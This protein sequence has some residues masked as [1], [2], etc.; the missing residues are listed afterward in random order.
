[1]NIAQ[2]TDNLEKLVESFNK[3]TFIFNLL[4]AYGTPKATISRLQK[5]D[6]NMFSK[7]IAIIKKKL[8]FN[9]VE[10][11]DLQTALNNLKHSEKVTKQSPRFIV[12]TDYETLLAYDTKTDESLDIPILEIAQ[13]TDFFLPWAGME[14]SKQQTENIADVRAAERMAKLY[15]EIRK[16]NPTTTHE[17]V[18]NLNVFLSRLLFCYFAEDTGIFDKDLFTKSI[19]YHTQKDGSDLSMYLD[20][21]F[22]VMNTSQSARKNDL[23]AYIKAF[24]YVNGGLFRDQH[25]APVFT[26]KSRQ[27]LIDCGLSLQWQ[28]INPDIFG[29]MIQAVITPE[30]RGGLGMHYTSVPNIMKVIEPLFLDELKEEFDAIV[31]TRRALSPYSDRAKLTFNALLK[32]IWNIKIFDP[33]CGSGNF[34]IIAYKE[35]RKLEMLIF[36]ELGTLAFSEINLGNFYGIELDDFAHEVATLS[37]WLAEHQMNQAFMREFGRCK[38]ALPLQETGNIVHGNACRIDWE[39]VCPKNKGD[40]IYILGNPPYLGGKGQSIEQKIDIE[41]IFKGE[42]NFKELDYIACWFLLAAKYIETK[43]KFAFVTTSSICEGAQ[44]EQIWPLITNMN[45]EIYFAY[46]PFNWTNN[47][48]NKAGVTCSI[49]GIRKLSTEKKYIFNRSIRKEVL[50][51]NGYLTSGDNIYITKNLESISRLPP[52]ITGNSPYENGNLMLTPDE[53]LDLLTNYPN[54]KQFIRKVTGANEYINGIERWCLWIEDEKL[55][56]ALDIPPVFKRIENIKLFRAAGG[57]VARG[58][59]NRPHKFRYTHTAKKSIIII[60]IVSSSRREYIPLGFLPAEYIILSSAAAIYD[61]EPYIF[62]ILTSKIH[63]NWVYLTSG[64]LRG[65]IRYLS[66]LSYNTFPFP[67]ISDKQKKELEQHI[68]NILGEREKHSE[69]TLAQLYDPE[70][71]PDGL[72]EAH[73]QNDLAVERCYRSRPFDSDEERLEYLFKLYEQMIEEEKEKGTLF[74]KPAKSTKKRI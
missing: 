46:I 12:V 52:M 54:A 68:Y 73:R 67:Q 65:D 31:Q 50:K 32:R 63:M 48:K 64:K 4:L 27:M 24:P 26:R 74:G 3:D 72:R 57:D 5:G 37:L 36:K 58:L 69:K 2:I 61:S 13:H 71:M 41:K 10:D 59:L 62:S 14:K 17:E 21:L 1:M 56:I 11:E 25:A 29:S 49:I 9:S 16:D 20:T 19:D 47:A 23:P 8:F 44:V 51:I 18:H 42:K 15:D 6:K 45:N 40:E 38:P 53:K 70:K 33:A 34:L 35:L 66:A 28:D 55:P 39:M 60:P 43:S 7:E 30:H 22:E